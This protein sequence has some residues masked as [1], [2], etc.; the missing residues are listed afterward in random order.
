VPPKKGHVISLKGGNLQ[1][2]G[3]GEEKTLR[4]LIQRYLRFRGGFSSGEGRNQKPRE[5]YRTQK[6]TSNK[7]GKKSIVK[8]LNRPCS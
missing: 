6:K 7:N 5:N 3:L 8:L 2:D 1:K 4:V